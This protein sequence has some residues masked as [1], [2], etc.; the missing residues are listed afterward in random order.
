MNKKKYSLDYL[1]QLE[2]ESIH[3]LR[4][5]VATFKNPVFLYSIGKDSSVMLHLARKAFT[6]GN[7]P[8]PVMHVDTGYQF[9][10]M[11]TFRD[12]IAQEYGLDLIV[13]KNTEPRALEFTAD[14]THSEEYIYYMKTKPLVEGLK[15]HKFDAAFGGARR[16][17]EKSRAKERIFSHR[18]ESNVWEPRAQRPELW[19]LYNSQI[20]EGESMRVFPISNWTELDIWMYIKRENIDIV[21]LY[22]AKKQKVV[23][24]GGAIF[25]VDNYLQPKEGEEVIEMD[26]RYRTLGCSPSTGAFP[27][28]ASNLEEVIEEIY[29]AEGSE[30]ESRMIDKNSESSMEQKKKEGYF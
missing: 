28:T 6:P 19:R 29:H 24:R 9:V 18:N 21:P 17:E 10:E 3:I 14:D 13:E 25:R 1:Q 8:F 23:N 26:C 27:S 30:R 11:I 12:R 20:K 7:L 15:K 5:S 22:F 4:E 16:D 2:S